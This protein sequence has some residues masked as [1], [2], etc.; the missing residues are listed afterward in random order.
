MNYALKAFWHHPQKA[1]AADNFTQLR[2]THGK[3]AHQSVRGMVGV[4]GG[5]SA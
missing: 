1:L 4:V 2:L 3:I 5:E